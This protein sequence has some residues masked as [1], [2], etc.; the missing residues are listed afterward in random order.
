MTDDPYPP[1]EPAG[2]GGGLRAAFGGLTT[3]G[4]SF[5]AAGGAAV[6]CSYVLGQEGLLRVGLLLAVL[7]LVC[8]LVLHRTRHRVA[9][10]RLL[11]PARVTA[12]Q[13]AQVRLRVA[14]VSRIPTGP[15]LVEDEVPWVLGPHP[16]FALDRMEPGGHREVAHRVRADLRGRYPLGP[17][18]LRL[19]D[20]FGMCEVTRGFGARAMLT[21]VPYCEPLPPLRVAGDAA[22]RGDG[23]LRTLALAG[24]DDIIPRAYRHGDDVRRIHWRATARTGELMVRREEQQRRAHAT[25][26]LDTRGVA[27][28][29][30][31]PGS[32]FERAVAA[33]ASVS[34]HLLQLGFAVR[35]LTDTGA[36]IPGPEGVGGRAGGAGL[37]PADAAG[38]LLD[39][40]AVVD[41]SECVDLS[42]ARDALRGDDG[43]L[44]VAFLG[45]LTEQEAA[46]AA[47]LRRRGVTALAFLLDPP[48][49]PG[50]PLGHPH[51]S[52]PLR[53]L[54]AAG[55]TALAMTPHVPFPDLWRLAGTPVGRGEA[56]TGPV[57]PMGTMGP[58]GHGG[59]GGWA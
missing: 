8:V 15:L 41:H 43:G 49:W 3:R 35:L 40:L 19:T 1:E 10:D 48:V 24:D 31:G 9:G 50:A 17:L 34:V 42:A 25:V 27:Y 7:P 5:L 28:A 52:P 22:G 39:A 14:N 4:R 23:S 33:A 54:H 16:R 12:G 59:P 32:P 46:R 53:T 21:A 56:V 6:V 18:R 51:A 11:S 55:W 57:G 20:P 38:T 13:E 44:L 36:W 26:L 2:D 45:G 58:M 29:G 37:D 30:A 47:G